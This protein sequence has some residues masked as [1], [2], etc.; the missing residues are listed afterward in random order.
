MNQ[1]PHIQIALVSRNEETTSETLKIIEGNGG[2][3]KFYAG[4]VTKDEEF[5]QVISQ[6]HLLY[7]LKYL[8]NQVAQQIVNEM[9]K[10]SV[11][12]FNVNSKTFSQVSKGTL[13]T[14]VDY[15]TSS[16]AEFKPSPLPYLLSTL[17]SFFPCLFRR[18]SM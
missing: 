3:A 9:G 2:E 10:P 12:V 16:I 11:V 8:T 13:G 1:L 7:L 5:K 17:L 15:C 18:I 14:P 4:D 6:N